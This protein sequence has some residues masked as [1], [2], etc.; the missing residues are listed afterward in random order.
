MDPQTIKVSVI[1]P[2]YNAAST[3]H[4]C[5]K[6]L[7]E[8]T[9][10]EVT[11]EIIVVDDASIDE[12]NSIA[13]EF[14]NIRILSVAHQ[15]PAAARNF[16]AQNARGAILLF[17][18][19]DCMPLN[20]WIEMMT[21]PFEDN[22]IVG[23]KGAY[24]SK[25]T[26]LVA[27]FVQAEYEDK[28]DRMKK[29][30]FIDFIDT[31]SAGYRKETFLQNGGFDSS[32][33]TSSVE[34]QEFSFRLA[35]RGYKMVFIPQARVIHLKHATSLREYFFKKYK[36]GYWKV[37]VHKLHPRKLVY[38]SH[39]P[40]SLK[41]QILLVGLII[42]FALFGMIMPIFLRISLFAGILFLS[43]TVPFIVK[44]WSKDKTVALLS[45]MLLLT[46]SIA[47]GLGFALGILKFALSGENSVGLKAPN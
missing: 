15:G 44:T 40:H 33:S 12:T 36:I 46:R 7:R 22:Q 18:D 1:I 9:I 30:K 17:T 2:A 14:P 3:L 41:F 24:F 29:E 31:Y 28:Y 16:G 4:Q 35:K 21:V 23:V 8:Q 10:P 37:R 45:P 43:T 6:A 38:D 32:F 25:Q 13:H 26:S 39:T 27:R 42:L 47:L 11:Y 19:A 34:D 20:N 5:L